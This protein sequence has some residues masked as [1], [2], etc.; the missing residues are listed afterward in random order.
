ML[1]NAYLN[2][3]GSS[4]AQHLEPILG[5]FQRLLSTRVH[6]KHAFDLLCTIFDSMDPTTISKY[7][8]KIFELVLIKLQMS[9]SSRTIR[10]FIH[11]M[12]FFS[13]K[14][15][16]AEMVQV[17]GWAGATPQIYVWMMDCF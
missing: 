7:Q 2:K 9:K 6:E 5:I 12:G 4:L 8:P 13:G 10:L 11:F 3:A 17:R 1:L 15:G 16:P 14:R